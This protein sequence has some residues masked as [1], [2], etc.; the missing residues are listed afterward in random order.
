MLT[1]ADSTDIRILIRVL[2][3]VHISS[4]KAYTLQH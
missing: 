4:F 3:E 1:A 2:A